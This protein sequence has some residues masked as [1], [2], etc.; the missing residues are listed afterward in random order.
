MAQAKAGQQVARQ[1]RGQLAGGQ[2]SLARRQEDIPT[3]PAESP[4][5]LVRRFSQD[6]ERFFGDVFSDIG[7]GQGLLPSA[8]EPGSALPRSDWSPAIEVVERD[9]AI[10]VLVDL[11]GLGPEDVNVQFMNDMLM[12]SGERSESDEDIAEGFRRSERCYGRFSRS[13]PLPQ[14]IDAENMSALFRDGVLEVSMPLPEQARGRLIE[15]QEEGGEEEKQTDEQLQAFKNALK[16]TEEI[17]LTVFGRKSGRRISQTVWFVQHDDTLYLLPVKGSDSEWF[18]NVLET[19]EI[20]LTA[21]RVSWSGRAIPITDSQQVQ[22]VVNKFRDKYGAD[23]VEK[24]YSK[25]DV[26]VAVPLS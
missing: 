22:E 20:M 4:F 24:Y 12:I 1:Q 26:A 2:R 5:S 14:G 3:I 21:R 9:D 13:I 6:M 16:G 10:V 15:I 23:Q 17:Q 8:A 7:I 11:P 19:P 18:K 25:F